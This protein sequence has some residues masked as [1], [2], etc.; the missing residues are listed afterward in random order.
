MESIDLRSDTVTQPTPE[1]RRAMYEAEWFR[2]RMPGAERYSL[3]ASRLRLSV[4]LGDSGEKSP[5]FQL[6][7]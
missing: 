1:M 2:R 6:L 7:P 5:S 3:R 4:H